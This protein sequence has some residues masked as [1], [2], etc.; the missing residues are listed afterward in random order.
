MAKFYFDFQK[1]T[2]LIA[3]DDEGQDLPCFEGARIA[4][5]ASAR[6]VLSSD[7]KFASADP[8]VAVIIKDETGQEIERILARDVLLDPLE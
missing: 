4:A 2:G 1:K 7:V 8:L 3:A 6:E 5:M